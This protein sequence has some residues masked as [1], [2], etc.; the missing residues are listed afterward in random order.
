M[1][2]LI[3]SAEYQPF[4]VDPHVFMY[5]YQVH[6]HAYKIDTYLHIDSVNEGNIND[7]PVYN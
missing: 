1:F 2:F 6:T 7:F 3:P 4:C 5:P